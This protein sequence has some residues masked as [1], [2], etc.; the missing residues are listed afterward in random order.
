MANEPTTEELEVERADRRMAVA[1]ASEFAEGK[2]DL[3]DIALA[4]I[5][6]I[7][8]GDV[9]KWDTVGNERVLN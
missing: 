3:F 6:F 8:N 7:A 2:E 4:V 1:V 5:G 9:P